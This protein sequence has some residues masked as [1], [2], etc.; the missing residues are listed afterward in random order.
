MK[1]TAAIMFEQGL[2]RPF[3][4][5]QPLKIETVDLEGPGAGEVLVRIAA[6]GLCHSDLSAI[7]GLRPRALPAVV[8]H[9]AAGVVV[10][11]GARV[12]DFSVGDHVVMVFVASCG[13]CKYCQAGRPGLCQSSWKARSEGTL[14][15]GAR[16]ISFKGRPINHYSGVS[17]FAEYAVVSE[18]SLVRISKTVAL[19]DAAI[20]GCAV[21]TGVGAVANAAGDVQGRSVAMIGLGG[22]GLS[23]LLGA[24]MGGAD[25][26]IAVDV[27][28]SKLKLALELGASHAFAATDPDIVEKIKSLTEGGVDFAFEMAGSMAAMQLAYA[29]GRRGNVTICAGLPPHAA[30]FPLPSATMVADERVIKGS[31]MGSAIPARDIPLYAE[32]FV[33]GRLPV[34]RLLTGEIDFENLNRGFDDLDDGVGVRQILNCGL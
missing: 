3:A 20:F 16:R 6:A 10:E 25:P 32:A 19:K 18:R 1:M 8:G 30:T 34:D 31:Y 28:D 21:I 24:R 14:Q 9:E 4:Q 5:S 7:K 11:T 27:H 33:S 23:A 15:S 17:A 29:V 22:V 2:E 12:R 13:T 26:L